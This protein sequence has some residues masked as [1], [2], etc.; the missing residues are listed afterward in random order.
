[1]HS[2]AHTNN[3]DSL[4]AA[5]SIVTDAGRRV[6]DHPLL[7]LGAALSALVWQLGHPPV[8]VPS[9]SVIWLLAGAPVVEEVIFRLGL[10]QELLMRSCTAPVANALTALAFALAHGLSQGSWQSLLTLL[11]GLA[12][13]SLY[14]RSR[15]LAPCISLPIAFNTFWLSWPGLVW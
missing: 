6:Q 11:P 1:M 3:V 7:W 12:M 13:G 10:Q 15:R 14:Q 8:V 5:E 4:Q 9:G 2:I